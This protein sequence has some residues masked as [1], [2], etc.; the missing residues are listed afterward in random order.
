MSTTILILYSLRIF[1][2]F[3]IFFQNHYKTVFFLLLQDG[4]GLEEPIVHVERPSQVGTWIC[5]MPC[6]WCR[7]SKAVHKAF[8]TFAMLLVTSLL[9]TSP[10]LFLIT[11]LP[12]G[13]QPRECLPLVSNHFF[14]QS[15]FREFIIFFN[16]IN[17]QLVAR[18][19]VH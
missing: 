16:S 4:Q 18:P 13:A 12:E 3:L 1:D 9:V 11:T 10:V 6:H 14:R 7:R 15:R 17:W 19:Q 2:E 5:C 8:L